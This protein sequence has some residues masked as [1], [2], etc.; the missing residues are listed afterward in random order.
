MKDSG[1]DSDFEPVLK[2]QPPLDNTSYPTP[3]R[4]AMQKEIELNKV[5]KRS[6]SSAF[7]DVKETPKNN[8]KDTGASN[9]PN[10]PLPPPLSPLPDTTN[11]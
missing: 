5:T 7:P 1:N 8:T 9:Q 2:P 11:T 6:A 4:I 10:M 3:T